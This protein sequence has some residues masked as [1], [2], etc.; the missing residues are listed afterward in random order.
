M[1]ASI[2]SSCL[3]YPFH[4]LWRLPIAYVHMWL[5]H[6]YQNLAQGLN[7]IQAKDHEIAAHRRMYAAGDVRANGHGLENGHYR[8]PEKAFHTHERHDEDPQSNHNAQHDGPQNA[9]PQNGWLMRRGLS[10]LLFDAW[11]V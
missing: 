10:K 9:G 3:I 5:D 8:G 4:V 6:A 7:A 2:R 11:S 1:D